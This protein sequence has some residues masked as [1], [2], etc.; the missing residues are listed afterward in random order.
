MNVLVELSGGSFTSFRGSSLSRPK[1]CF[2]ASQWTIDSL[3]DAFPYWCFQ[4]IKL[5]WLKKQHVTPSLQ[6]SS[7]DCSML[8]W[9]GAPVCTWWTF[10]LWKQ[11]RG[12]GIFSGHVPLQGSSHIKHILIIKLLWDSSDRVSV[13]WALRHQR[14]C[15]EISEM[16][17]LIDLTQGAADPVSID[18]P[19]CLHECEAPRAL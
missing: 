13:W 15:P 7:F 8:T 9:V 2:P 5:G 18:F 14:C 1:L 3:L 12:C 4:V 6:A 10:F 19:I 17:T 16:P 11:L